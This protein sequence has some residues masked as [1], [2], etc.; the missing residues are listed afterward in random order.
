MLQF[1]GND[2]IWRE[3]RAISRHR[4]CPLYV[5]VPYL[6]N[7][8]GKLLYLK[9]GDVLI[10][11]LTLANS[12]NGSVCPSEIGR[13]QAKGVRVFL[14]P[15]LSRESDAVRAQGRRWLCEPLT[16]LVRASG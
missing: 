6:G 4:K 12:R 8:G 11:A 3:L 16:D 1:L 14:A 13:L 15:Y 7:A 9:R 10:V 2:D 5:A